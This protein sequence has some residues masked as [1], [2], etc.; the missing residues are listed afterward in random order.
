MFGLERNGGLGSRMGSSFQFPP[1]VVKMK[2]GEFAMGNALTLYVNLA[3]II[4]GQEIMV[5][6]EEEQKKT[7]KVQ[8]SPHSSNSY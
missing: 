5:I 6:L 2:E 7:E 8:G 3:K 4:Y 1:G